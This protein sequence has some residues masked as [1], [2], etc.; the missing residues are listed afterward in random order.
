MGEKKVK[1]EIKFVFMYDPKLEK[2][3]VVKKVIN[4]MDLRPGQR[5]RYCDVE[6]IVDAGK[7]QVEI[8][9]K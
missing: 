7:A 6:S 5:L 2:P 8:V 4:S 9:D 3:Y 1:R